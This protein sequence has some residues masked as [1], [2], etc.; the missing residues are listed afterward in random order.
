MVTLI[1]METRS[2]S[3]KKV[4]LQNSLKKKFIWQCYLQKVQA[5]YSLK[6]DQH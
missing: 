2:T 3:V 5:K 1:H 6:G 4:F